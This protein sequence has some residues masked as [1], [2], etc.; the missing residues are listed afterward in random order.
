M[1]IETADVAIVGGGPA[2]L[3]AAGE[4]AAAGLSVI[5]VEENASF[6]GQ[7]WRSL[8]GEFEEAARKAAID[9]VARPWLAAASHPRVRA[10]FK[11]LVWGAFGQGQLEA[12]GPDGP[13]RICA[14]H[15]ILATGAHDRPVPLPGWT[16]PGVM[17][18]GGGQV[19][20]KGQRTLPRGRVLLAG[21][22]PL[23]LVV[24]AQ[25]ARAGADIAG[26]AEA[27]SSVSLL[28]H[29]PALIGSPGLMLRGAGYRL[30]LL[31]GR[32]P[33]HARTVVVRIEGRTSVEAAVL[34]SLDQNG[35]IRPGTERRV[36][37]DMVLL[38]YGLVPSLELARHL[39]CAVSFD[40]V[41]KS[42]T[43][44]RSDAF[45]TSRPGV[46]AVGDGAGVAGAV[47]AVEEGRVAGLAV[48]RLSGRLSSDEAR[49]RQEIPRRR[50]RRL[51]AFRTAMDT[52][53]RPPDVLG[54]LAAPDTVL[55]RCEDVT[56]AQVDS[57]I[58]D[59]AREAAQ[60]KLWTRAGMGS[61]Q[62]RS[63]HTSVATALSRAT[64]KTL[65]EVGSYG[66]RAPIKPLDVEALLRM[67]D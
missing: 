58:A 6:G 17:T 19:L 23:L 31:L 27:A 38:G 32:V 61:C 9:P 11:T 52:V 47:V 5:L 4:A 53:Y 21:T 12:A 15:I 33:W 62:G 49:F 14:P 56:L 36:A 37:C 24:A 48:A 43:P 22:G 13:F 42:F 64:G 18:V 40:P 54:T 57:A 7:I 63:C 10:F 2:G 25:Y 55:C 41:R 59:G 35:R 46:F 44:D 66:V 26:V 8:P 28:R 67:E 51:Q 39:G 60:V 29:S 45:E 3:A 1:R 30:A 20:L 34:A 50:L 16:L 65:A